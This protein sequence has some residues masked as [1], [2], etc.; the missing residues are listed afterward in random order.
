MGTSAK[1]KQNRELDDKQKLIAYN[2]YL[3]IGKDGKISETVDEM[4][5]RVA[6]YIAS[7]EKFYKTPKKEIDE[8]INEFYI[9]HSNFEFIA[10]FTLHDRG[11]EKLMAE[12]YVLPLEDSLE[13]IYKTLYQS[14][15]LHRLGAGI[16][17]D[18]SP[19]RPEGSR[20]NST[21]KEASGPISF[22]RLYD[23]SSEIILNRGSARHAG[24]MGVL[25]IDHP[26]IELFIEAKEDY[27]QLTNFN[28]SVAITDKFMTAYNGNKDFALINPIDGKIVKK[29][30]ARV[31][32]Y[33]IAQSAH[34]S[35]EPG[36]IF[37]DEVNKK[38]P[39]PGAG[40]ITAT[41]LCGEQP[42]LPY[43]ACNIGSVVLPQ[44][45][46]ENSSDKPEK[47]INW[48]RLEEVVKLGI[49]YLDNTLDLSYYP[50]K[51]S[52]K[53]MTIDNRKVGL[54][55]MGWADLLVQLK[56]PY[57]SK[58]AIDV[59]GTVM[60]FVRDKARE[61]SSRLGEK[62][63]N[64]KNFSKSIFPKLGYK[65]MRNGTSTTIAPTG[66]ISLFSDCNGGIE[67]FFALAY[68]RRNM[69]TLGET[70]LVYL[71]RHLEKT[72]KDEWLYS[73]KLMQK[74]AEIGNI[75]EIDQ[76]PDK[77]KKIYKT[78]YDI[79]PKDHILMQAAFQKN[80]DNAVSKTI[81]V[82]KDITVKEIEQ[83]YVLAYEHNLKGITI[84]RDKSRDAQVLN[85]KK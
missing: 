85:V 3:K 63:G 55:V 29:V 82:P 7:A 53:I 61:E 25:R 18:F 10:G 52:K 50:L 56:I 34:K 71:N 13:S 41:N 40:D 9:I 72:L 70:T 5:H 45:Y 58:Q 27:T 51:E 21:G 33:M 16:G 26:D 67:P 57:D 73:K 66:T 43:E 15:Q 47:H 77:V 19:I 84:Y 2:R 46:I 81:N 48:K 20:V 1:T 64:F 74:I 54:G 32:M 60:K 39:I 62:R 80:V 49:R 65:Y 38:H 79:D 75:Q 22:M 76:I 17:Y 69:E 8:I 44:F 35:G 12:C 36:V 31:L 42:L 28:I 68:E 4:F 14:V 37:I 59:A 24:H 78:S 83:L 23:F 11:R 6:K 30:P